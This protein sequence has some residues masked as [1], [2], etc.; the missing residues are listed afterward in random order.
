MNFVMEFEWL[1]IEY[2]IS[3]GLTIFSIRC[4]ISEKKNLH[5]I[6]K[7]NLFKILNE[8]STHDRYERVRFRL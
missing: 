1:D 7:G 5:R 3:V 2:F 6:Y 4:I 8:K